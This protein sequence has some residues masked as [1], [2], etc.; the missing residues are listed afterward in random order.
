LGEQQGEISARELRDLGFDINLAPVLDLASTGENPG[1]T[2]RS[3]GGP[4]ELVSKLGVSLVHGTLRGG[5]QPSLKHF[6]GK[7]EATVDAHLDLPVIPEGDQGPHLD[8][9]I[10][11]IEAGASIVMTSHVVFKQMDAER[12]A[13]L[14]HAVVTGLLRDQMGF[15]GVAVTDD[16]EMG[17]MQKHFGF[18]AMIKGASE[19]GHDVFCICHTYE[20]Q[21]RARDL[22]LEGMAANAQ[23]VGDLERIDARLI[24][25]RPPVPNAAGNLPG[26]ESLA[27][28]IAGRA[29]T[30]HSDPKSLIPITGKKTLLLMP[31]LATLTGVENPLRG[32]EDGSALALALGEAVQVQRMPTAPSESDLHAALTR[33][34]EFECVL[35]VT[36]NARFLPA[37]RAFL[38]SVMSAHSGAIHL[39]IRSPFD[40]EVLPASLPS[41]IVFS[42]G[43]RPSQLRALAQVLLGATKAYGRSPV[44]I[45]RDD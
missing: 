22:L 6:P 16:M 17:A 4:S 29:I 26:G 10:R 25:L 19:A 24:R 35:V 38:L 2:I 5:I 42:Y 3:F 15:D 20:L 8:P 36:T 23:W 30:V 27:L 7:G 33:A 32:E 43:F 34:R 31:T 11:C 41:T 21:T 14:S 37:Q 44:V 1:I 39:A 12:P 40:A 9:F 13:T 28:A 18:D 45:S